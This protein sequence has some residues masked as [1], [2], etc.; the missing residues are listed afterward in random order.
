MGI[1]SLILNAAAIVLLFFVILSGVKHTAPLRDTYFLRVNTSTFAG[2]RRAISQWTYF[3][4]CGE[5]NRDCGA[6]VPALPFGAAWRGDNAGVPRD[7][8]GYV[9][10]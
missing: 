8:V 2:T 9:A 1:A 4:I 5:G 3:Y 7:L 10:N 6:A